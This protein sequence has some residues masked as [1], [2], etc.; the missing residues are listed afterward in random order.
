MKTKFIALLLF[1]V[2]LVACT[3]KDG[4]KANHPAAQFNTN[5]DSLSYALGMGY[6]AS[7]AELEMILDKSGSDKAFIEQL[8]KGVKDGISDANK[9]ELAYYIGLEAG[10]NMRSQ[11]IEV[12]EEQLFGD[13]S[14]QQLN[15]DNFIAGFCDVIDGKQ[16]FKVNGAVLEPAMATDYVQQTID[17]IRLDRFTR[18][19]PKERK[20]S[21]DFFRQIAQ[22]KGIDSLDCG[23]Y[24][25]VLKKGRGP[26][27]TI[28]NIVSIEYEGK[29]IDGTLITTSH[30]ITDVAVKDGII[31][32]LGFTDMVTN[33]PLGS[34][35]IGYIPWQLCYGPE[36]YSDMI[37]P[38]SSIIFKV[39]LYNIK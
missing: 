16:D 4:D 19:Y 20:A 10:V 2:G 7:K 1:C 17:Q 24:Y 26:K 21:D 23:I 28:G 6:S 34:E 35:W 5:I 27:P 29:L 11:I 18:R 33:M 31:N 13:D 12:A 14:T 38:F 25:K 15:I 30:A 32:F 8:L 9:E 37:P 3:E 36:G 22:E 39:K